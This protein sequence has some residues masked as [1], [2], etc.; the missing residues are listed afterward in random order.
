MILRVGAFEGRGKFHEFDHG[1]D[2][3]RGREPQKT[4]NFGF[5][6]LVF[7]AIAHFRLKSHIVFLFHLAAKHTEALAQKQAC[8][9]SE[10]GATA[11]SFAQVSNSAL[12]F[13]PALPTFLA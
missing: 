4:P 3:L 8:V 6:G 1:F 12:H 13:H 7:E 9:C 2:A 5:H 10:A 11:S